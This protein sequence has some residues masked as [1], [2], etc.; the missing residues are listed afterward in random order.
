ML[1]FAHPSRLGAK[2]VAPAPEDFTSISYPL[3][4][5]D[6][7]QLANQATP[8]G[9]DYSETNSGKASAAIASLDELY[10]PMDE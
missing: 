8:E 10:R 2:V 9:Y 6:P 1:S 3:F 7:D 5:F 4:W